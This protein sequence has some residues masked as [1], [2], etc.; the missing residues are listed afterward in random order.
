MKLLTHL[1]YNII[2]KSF[3]LSVCTIAFFTGGE[4]QV[5]KEQALAAM[6]HGTLGYEIFTC[7][8][9]N[10]VKLIKG[11]ESHDLKH[12]VLDYKMTPLDEIR[13]Q[14]FMLGNGNITFPCMAILL[15]GMLLLPSKWHLF[16]KDFRLGRRSV[17]ISAWTIEHYA[18][19]NLQHLRDMVFAPAKPETKAPLPQAAIISY[20]VLCAGIVGMLFCLPFL[21]SSSVADLVGAG[22]PLGGAILVAGGLISLSH[23]QQP[24]YRENCKP[25]H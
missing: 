19:K 5:L 10:R 21:F 24:G 6:P 12:V 13:M 3:D 7:L 11:F 16:L 17:A 22:F 9:G 18:H 20:L 14:A 4:K 2:K 1:S 15:F 23:V 8:T 25:I